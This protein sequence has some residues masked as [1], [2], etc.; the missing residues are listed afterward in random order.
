MRYLAALVVVLVLGCGVATRQPPA[1]DTGTPLP[2]LPGWV[3]VTDRDQSVS[4]HVGQKIEVVLT[5]RPRMTQWGPITADDT[6]VL[7]PVPTGI[8]APIGVTVAGFA[9]LKPG[10]ATIRSTAGPQCSPGQACPMY[11]VL[12]SV[13]VTVT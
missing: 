2:E 9:A 13:R 4:V 6:T 12:F 5:E 8:T 10:T 7:Q 3:L 1:P 11:A